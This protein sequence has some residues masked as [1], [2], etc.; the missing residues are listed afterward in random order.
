[1]GF[2]EKPE[3]LSAVIAVLVVFILYSIVNIL[4][5]PVEIGTN[6]AQSTALSL[7]KA[8]SAL[9]LAL[10]ILKVGMHF[11]RL[12]MVWGIAIFLFISSPVLGLLSS[13]AFSDHIYFIALGFASSSCLIVITSLLVKFNWNTIKYVI[14]IQHMLAGFAPY[15][16]SIVGLNDIK[17]SEYFFYILLVISVVVL[18]MT[19]GIDKDFQLSPLK[20]S[21]KSHRGDSRGQL[22]L[23]AMAIGG[24]A[25]SLFLFG[26]YEQFASHT[27]ALVMYKPLIGLINNLGI[28][29][30]LL[31]TFLF[32]KDI[33]IETSFFLVSIVS[34]VSLLIA[35]LNSQ[36]SSLLPL[37]TQTLVTFFHLA[38]WLF[39]FKTGKSGPIHVGAM[40][41]FSVFTIS[42]MRMCGNL[43]AHLSL[44][45]SEAPEAVNAVTMWALAAFALI[46]LSLFFVT[47]HIQKRDTA[48]QSKTESTHNTDSAE[49]MQAL[50]DHY[51]LSKR[52]REILV[53]YAAGRSAPFIAEKYFLSVF[54]IKNY[55]SRIY[56]KMGIHSRQELLDCI[57]SKTYLEDDS[58]TSE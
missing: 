39:I 51:L 6:V 19:K 48:H 52:E 33:S 23:I 9:L 8:G 40:M 54:T 42:F 20:T 16:L 5:S 35:L 15:T 37:V 29:I 4:Q 41:G 43:T 21:K 45:I 11:K 34:F 58:H 14:V 26:I 3:R 36:F 12:L 2:T 18:F 30:A 44:T 13:S 10:Y 17:A 56:S 38:I 24:A 22:L 57:E 31:I 7:S 27:H 46:N 50:A 53:E 25:L 55:I 1:M 32:K 47:Y 28:P 49:N